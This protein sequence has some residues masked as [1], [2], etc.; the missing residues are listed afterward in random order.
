VF[1]VVII[2]IYSICVNVLG[3]R[4]TSNR[5]IPQLRALSHPMHIPLGKS[6]RPALN[7]WALTFHDEFN[8]TT[9]NTSVWNVED[10]GLYHYQNCCLYFGSQSFTSRAVFLEKH[11][12]HIISNKDRS[13]KVY[14]SGAVTTENK[15]SFLYGRVDI[16]ARFPWGQGM[17]PGLWMLTANA[18]REVDIMEMVNDPT[19]VYQTYHLNVPVSNTAAPQCVIVG[20][21]LSRAFHV[22]TLI[23]N[24]SSLTWYIDGRQTCHIVNAIPK[25]P[26]Y[27]L[28]DA[29]V[30]GSWPGLPDMSTTFPQSAVID[31]VRVYQASRQSPC[32]GLQVTSPLQLADTT[33]ALGTSIRGTVTYANLCTLPFVLLDLRIVVRTLHGRNADF[34]NKGPMILRAGQS[35]TI[36]AARVI[37]SR[38]LTGVGYAFSSFETLDGKWHSDGTNLVKFTVTS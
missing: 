9:L 5:S 18:D 25:T 19:V 14:T 35:V 31:Y 8:G 27:L 17:W 3:T 4:D 34:G 6:N 38:D 7:G 11:G 22:F 24:I 28:L 30:G 26:M 23:W 16:S 12:L 20:Q 1:L 37:D 36:D 21:N 13:G 15:F 29:A 2:F 32:S 10:Y 33:L